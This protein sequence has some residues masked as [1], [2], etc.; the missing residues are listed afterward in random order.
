MR[1]FGNKCLCKRSRY[2]LAFTLLGRTVISVFPLIPIASHIMRE[3]SVFCCLKECVV[4]LYVNRDDDNPS[5]LDYLSKFFF[6]RENNP[7]PF[8]SP[9]Y[10]FSYKI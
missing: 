4:P 2:V 6:V 9:Q 7:F 5:R 1:V 8:L 10:M 3:P